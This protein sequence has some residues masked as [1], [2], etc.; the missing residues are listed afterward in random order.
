MPSKRMRVVDVESASYDEIKDAVV[1]PEPP[2]AEV[3]EQPPAAEAAE[4][5]VE[6]KPVE[7]KPVE[8]KPIEEKP[9]EEKPDEGFVEVKPKKVAPRATCEWCNREMTAKNL[10]YSHKAICPMRPRDEETPATEE[11][12]AVLESVVEE[13]PAEAPPAK[14]PPMPKLKR[15]VTVTNEVSEQEPPSEAKPKSKPKSKPKAKPKAKPSE[16]QS[17][18]APP[19]RRSKAVAKAELY[20]QLVAKALP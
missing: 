4:P 3:N 6:E 19:V 15:A 12:P 14:A 10:K 7:E 5:V 16:P 20:E 9:V 13:P 17:E 11:P 2:A 1:A 18:A 8:D